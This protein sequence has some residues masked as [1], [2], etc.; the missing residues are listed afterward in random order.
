MSITKAVQV[1]AISFVVQY[2]EDNPSTASL[3][4]Y[5]FSF[6]GY[7][8]ERYLYWWYEMWVPLNSQRVQMRC[9]LLKKR[10][11][12]PYDHPVV[13]KWPKGRFT[14]LLKDVDE[15]IN[16]IWQSMLDMI[17]HIVTMIYLIV[18]CFINLAASVERNPHSNAYVAYVGVFVIL[19]FITMAFPF[20]WF[21][22]FHSSVQECETMIRE[23]QA[24]YMSSS[25]DTLSTRVESLYQSQSR[26][27]D[28][29]CDEEQQRK[30]AD[31]IAV[32]SYWLYGRTTFRAFF[33]R[34]A[35]QTNFGLITHV[36]GPLVAYFLLKEEGE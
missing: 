8:L 18:L 19:G 6:Y 12:L 7:A 30:R 27:T 5:F 31:I 10:S 4:L 9:V 25:Y 1:A 33:H 29:H 2:I 26:H 20:G 13:Q 28:P 15:I 3:G 16:G 14:G 24:L 34:L 36:W 21:W 17:D 11:R 22:M 35:W 32:K 23:G